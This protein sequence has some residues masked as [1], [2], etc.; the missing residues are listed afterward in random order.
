L[1]GLTQIGFCGRQQAVDELRA[2]VR[3][4]EAEKQRLQA[5]VERLQTGAQA[6]A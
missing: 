1:T 2:R 3:E 4:V 5:E 6:M